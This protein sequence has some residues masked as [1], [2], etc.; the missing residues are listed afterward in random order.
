VALADSGAPQLPHN[1]YTRTP[2]AETW[3]WMR[4]DVVGSGETAATTDARRTARQR[5]Q[6]RNRL[7]RSRRH[8]IA[9]SLARIHQRGARPVVDA[10]DD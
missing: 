3:R 7:R 5:R 1:E 4:R 9:R 2:C 10:V 6:A 8:C